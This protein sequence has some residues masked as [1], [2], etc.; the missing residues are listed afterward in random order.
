MVGA[1]SRAS[2]A[3]SATRGDGNNV[4]QTPD[5]KRSKHTRDVASGYLAWESYQRAHS[6]RRSNHKP[7]HVR[8]YA[9]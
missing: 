6:G 9:I 4:R 8:S 3:R 5:S 1:V 7:H 2:R